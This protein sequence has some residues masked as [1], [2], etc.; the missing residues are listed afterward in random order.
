MN[1]WTE[2]RD[3]IPLSVWLHFFRKSLEKFHE[4]NNGLPSNLVVISFTAQLIA[5]C[6]VHNPIKKIEPI[7]KSNKSCILTETL[8][9]FFFSI[10]LLYNIVLRCPRELYVKLH[11]QLQINVQRERE[12]NNFEMKINCLINKHTHYS[13]QYEEHILL[14][15]NLFLK[16]Y[17]FICNLFNYRVCHLTF[18]FSTSSCLIWQIISFIL[19]PNEYGCIYAWTALRSGPAI[20]LHKMPMLAKKK[21]II[22]SCEKSER[23]WRPHK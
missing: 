8:F 23:N 5:T 14:N 20:N 21:K 12:R 15:A 2:T 1:N 13:F 19:P 9:L 18:F 7:W 3:L 6:L 17:T 22:L 10:L 16:V 11:N 4:K